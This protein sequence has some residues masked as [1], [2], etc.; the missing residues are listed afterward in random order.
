MQLTQTQIG[1]TLARRDTWA[2]NVAA[3]R[4][5]AWLQDGQLHVKNTAGSATDVPLTGTTVGDLYGGQKSG[6]TTIPAGSE[7]TFAPND[8]ANTAAPTVSGTVRVGATV[9]AS[10][11]SWSGTPTIDYGYQWQRCDTQGNGCANI[12]GATGSAYEVA[13]ADSG[14][15]LRVVVSAG[16]WISSVSQ[17]ASDV[18]GKAAPAP[19]QQSADSSRHAGTK[20]AP[21]LALTKV[22]MSP[23]RFP[24]SHRARPR[25]TRLDGSRVTWKLNKTATVKLTFQ[26]RA[27]TKKHRRWVKVGTIKRSAKTGTGVVRFTGRF[28]RKLL[29]PGSYRLVATARVKRENAGPKHV[30]FAVRRG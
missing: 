19:A 30:A 20:K 8:P 14:A 24:V 18:T 1:Q 25:G 27:G 28:G 15:T 23:R 9:T 3:G 4:V 6:W 29:R 21:R 5:S 17:A 11:G 26:R 10:N 2:S 22:K 16:N 13:G 7:R 12:A